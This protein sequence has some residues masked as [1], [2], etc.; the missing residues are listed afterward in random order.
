MPLLVTSAAGVNG[1]GYGALLAF[2]LDGKPLGAFSDDKRIADPRGLAVSRD[3]GLLFLNSGAD[4]VLAIDRDGKVV[5]DTGTIDGL[6]P[7]GGNFGLDGRYYVGLRSARTIMEFS[8]KLETAGEPVLPTGVVPFPRG[9]AFGS[10]GRLFLAS[11]IG[12]DGVGENTIVAFS[13]DGRVLPSWRVAD[14]DLSPLDLA[15]APNGNVLV[16]SEHPFGAP[17]AAT[18]VREYDATDGHLVRA[19]SPDPQTKVRKPRGLRFGANGRLY[20]VALNEVVAFDFD[21]G[22]FLGTTVH[23]PRLNGQALA[24]FP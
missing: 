6:N 8:P 24:F 15:I 19:F 13:P 7:G 3:D 1:D 16:S 20:C 22:K 14:P 4:R 17:D 18:S 11:G 2:D 10:D 5:R 23:M 9:F 12:P 21:S